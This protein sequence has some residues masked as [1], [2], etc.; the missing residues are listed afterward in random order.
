MSKD[1]L[2]IVRIAVAMADAAAELLAADDVADR[3][4]RLARDALG[5]AGRYLLDIA[6]VGDATTVD[7]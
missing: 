1:E 6:A 7:T 5:L 3:E 4:R 2:G